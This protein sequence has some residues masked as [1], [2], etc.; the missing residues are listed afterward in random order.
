MTRRHGTPRRSTSAADVLGGATPTRQRAR[1]FVE[2]W[3]PQEK[4]RQLLGQVQEIIEEYR[5]YL[6]LT[7]RQ[8]FYR[9][10]AQ[11]AFPKTEKAYK[12]DLCELM[13]MA[14][15]ARVISMDA[16][17][18]DSLT[19]LQPYAFA[20]KEEFLDQV[21]DDA[22]GFTLDRTIGQK[23]RLVVYCEAAGMAPQLAR[24]A[25]EFGVKVIASGGFNSVTDKHN[26][27]VDI[28]DSSRPVE[29]L[30]VGDHDP[31]GGHMFVTLMEDVTAFAED[32]GGEAIFTRVAVTPDQV[33]SHRLPTAPP[34]PSDNRAFHGM[35]C[36][37]EALA[38]DVMNAILRA[39]IEQRINKAQL[40]RLLEQERQ[41][42]GELTDLLDAVE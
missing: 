34:K 38:P 3:N 2:S 37:A 22:A 14:R 17:R 5:L 8:I 6:P 23:S 42:R 15:R 28:A 24:V 21:R 40:Q 20:S 30:H 33:R 9:L 26:L 39:A 32:L 27:A 11:Y 1:G 31:S 18:D 36:Q 7:V 4:K 12:N 19:T 16:I 35:T 13:T 10:V 29:V 25:H 41:I